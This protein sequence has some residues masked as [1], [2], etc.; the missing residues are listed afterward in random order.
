LQKLEN[1]NE[2]RRKRNEI[3]HFPKIKKRLKT[4]LTQK[5]RRES[6][7]IN[8]DDKTAVVVSIS[9]TMNYALWANSLGLWVAV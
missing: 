5:K 4:N 3:L 8:K 7:L 9:A 2:N 6:R 1:G